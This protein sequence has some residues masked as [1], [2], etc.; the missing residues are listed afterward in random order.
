LLDQKLI[1]IIAGCAAAVAV[2]VFVVA[3]QGV[4]NNV[5][6][7]NE[8]EKPMNATIGPQTQEITQGPLQTYRINTECELIYGFSSGVYPDGGKMSTIKIADLVQKYPDE[9]LPW[10]NI[11]EDNETR[12]TFL[13]HRF[14]EDFSNVVVSAVMKELSINPDLK[15][16]AMLI[17][18]PEGNAKLR[19]AFDKY[20]CQ[21]YF[22]SRTIH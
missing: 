9:F 14:S 6:V 20:D 2:I 12:T 1:G 11:L 22:D 10:K 19:E 5:P 8:S 13:K 18:D 4:F 16:I 21:E 3:N 15:S 17:T 7:T